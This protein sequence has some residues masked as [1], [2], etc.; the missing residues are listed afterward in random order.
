VPGP[1]PAA[2]APGGQAKQSPGRLGAGKQLEVQRHS[3]VNHVTDAKLT[4]SKLELLSDDRPGSRRSE[5]TSPMALL[6][7]RVRHWHGGRSLRRSPLPD[8]QVQ[9]MDEKGEA[10]L[11][12][13][14]I[15]F[16]HWSPVITARK[17]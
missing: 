7:V 17:L 10:L 4:P 6:G 12:T 15:V 2:S 8:T 11:E 3:T 16:P 9:D 14:Q 5:V 1:Q 13:L